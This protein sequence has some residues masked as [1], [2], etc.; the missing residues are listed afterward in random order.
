M[1]ICKLPNKEFEIVVL[2]KLSKL[3]ENTE[4]QFSEIK[5]TTHKQN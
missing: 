2:K 4:R 5:K 3:Q 1:E